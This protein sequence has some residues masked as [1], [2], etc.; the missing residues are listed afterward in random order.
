MTV[1]SRLCEIP[2]TPLGGIY[3]RVKVVL[4]LLHEP[5]WG[6][7]CSIPLHCG[8]R[9]IPIWA[10]QAEVAGFQTVIPVTWQAF[11]GTS[12]LLHGFSFPFLFFFIFLAGAGGVSA[13]PLRFR[14][15]GR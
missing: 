4:L 14:V 6:S 2:R 3:P 7:C 8:P 10:G 11:F 1:R 13:L 12:A 15:M 9:R 5:K